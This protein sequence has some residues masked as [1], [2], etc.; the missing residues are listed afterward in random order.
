MSLWQWLYQY[1]FRVETEGWHYIPNQQQVLLV[2]S[3]NGGLL[4]PDMIMCMYDWFRNFGTER[5]VYGLMHPH[6]WIINPALA[7]LAEKTGAIEAHPK[8]A[9]AALSKKASLLVYPGGVQDVFRPH[10]QRYKINFAGRKSFIKLALRHEIPIIPL[11][12]T[13]A[14]DTLI[15]LGDFYELAQQLHQMG[16][17][18]LF[19]IDP[20]VFPIYL[21]LP[22]G[23][24]IGP[25]PNI[26][27]PIKIRTRV[28]PP[29]T[30]A[31]YGAT[32]AKDRLY[33]DAC[34][35]LVV[36]QMQQQLDDLAG[37]D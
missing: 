8:M 26:P 6:A 33:I 12:S 21:G 5:L 16:M 1:Y 15:I 36:A 35:D 17:P 20:Q 25:L 31:K 18:W 2:G 22:W 14:H 13:G 10:S 34:Y 3:H 37:L 11:I 29:I 9:I 30:F 19:D 28:C 24:S 27:L 4:A 32:A 23:V 7:K